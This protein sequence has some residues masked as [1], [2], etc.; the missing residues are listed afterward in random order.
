MRSRDERRTLRERDLDPSPFRQFARWFEEAGRAQPELPEAVTL[1]T[2]GSDG[3]VSARVVLLKSFDERGFVFYT[4]YDSRKGRQIAE[5][6]RVALCFFWPW[7]ER[8]VRVEGV[9]EPTPPEE[10]D[11]YFATRPRGSQLGAWASRQGAVLRSRGALD[12]RV[13]A[14]EATYRD[15]DV[16][17]PPRWGGYRVA[18]SELEF[19]Q[20]RPDRLHDR[21]VYR[22]EP[23]GWIIERLSP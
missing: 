12:R 5:S 3:A 15:R 11:A 4:S 10:S 8:Q 14:L 22:R 17:R 21:L 9:A 2:C 13:R 16:P 19:W 6:Q 23:Q 1:A 18:P 7:L 20:G